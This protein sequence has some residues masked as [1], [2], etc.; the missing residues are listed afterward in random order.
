[1]FGSRQ[2]VR[3]RTLNPSFEGS[4]PSSRASWN[5][6]P[7]QLV[8]VFPCTFPAV[9][10]FFVE[11]FL[12]SVL[13]KTISKINPNTVSFLCTPSLYVTDKIIQAI[14]FSKLFDVFLCIMR[15]FLRGLLFTF[16]DEGFVNPV[17][18]VFLQVCCFIGNL[19]NIILLWILFSHSISKIKVD[20]QNKES[21]VW[22]IPSVMSCRGFKS[23]NSKRLINHFSNC[24]PLSCS[25]PFFSP[26]PIL[27]FVSS[28][29]F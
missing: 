10:T 12:L 2:V 9:R 4:N 25:C 24:F 1:M 11:G 8:F 20:H 18:Q 16:S 28:I 3:Q 22:S 19:Y 29:L 5:F 27:G 23:Y 26:S 6:Q 13:V 17:S 15:V 7:L 21:S 14:S